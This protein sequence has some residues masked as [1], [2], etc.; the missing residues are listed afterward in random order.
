[1]TRPVFLALAVLVHGG[2]AL[3]LGMKTFG[4]AMIIGNLAFLYPEYVRA[5]ISCL[6]R[7]VRRSGAAQ[8]ASAPNEPLRRQSFAATR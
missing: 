6:G 1:M 7:C 2:I 3:A 4:L 8:T 5:T